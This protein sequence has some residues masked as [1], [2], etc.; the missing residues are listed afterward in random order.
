MDMW[1]RTSRLKC[2][3]DESS[4]CR[5]LLQIKTEKAK[6]PPRIFLSFRRRGK[7]VACS[8]LFS[9]IGPRDTISFVSRWRHL[10]ACVW[11]VVVAVSLIHISW[12]PVKRFRQKAWAVD[13]VGNRMERAHFQAI[14]KLCRSIVFN[15]LWTVMNVNR[16][17]RWCH[18]KCQL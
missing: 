10:C 17:A 14:N 6:L 2:K 11:V 8:A 7:S 4:R 5:K 13:A 16:C 12:A 15:V 3:G 18:F 9:S 1:E